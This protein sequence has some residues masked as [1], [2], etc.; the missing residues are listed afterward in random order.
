MCAGLQNTTDGLM[1]WLRGGGADYQLSTD[2]GMATVFEVH[3]ETYTASNGVVITPR[4]DLTN[5]E[6]E[7]NNRWTNRNSTLYSQGYLV[8][9]A[10]NY[11][12]YTV[13]KTGSGASGT[14]GI[15]ISGN[16]NTAT[17]LATAR[18]F[19]IADNDGTNKGPTVSFNGSTNAIINLP[20]V[21]KASLSG[22]AS[23]AT[24]IQNGNYSIGITSNLTPFIVVNGSQGRVWGIERYNTDYQL[25]EH[26]YNNGTYET[27]RISLNNV[28]YSGYALPLSGGTLTGLLTITTN[29]RYV[30]LGCQNQSFAHYSTNADSGHWF[31]TNVR[32]QGDI[33][34]GNSYDKKV[35]SED[36]GYLSNQLISHS[37]NG[38][39]WISGTHSAAF[40]VDTATSAPAGN[41]YQ[42]WY[43]GK[44]P[45][46]AWSLGCLAGDESM[47]FVYGSDADFQAGTNNTAQLRMTSSGVLFGAA[48]NDYAEFRQGQ[49]EYKPGTCV[50]EVG[51]DTLVAS[52]ERLQG[53]AL[54]VSDTFGFAI[55]ETDE[56]K[57]PIATSGRVLAYTFEPRESY[58]AGD[59]VCSGPN[60]TVSKMTE[61]EVMM[62]PHKMIGTVSAIPDYEE[63]GTGKVKVDGR[64][65]IQVR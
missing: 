14:W 48:W 1:V 39:M 11:T 18:T 42:A 36:G 54:I 63:W 56:A 32:V 57:T 37:V 20:S 38:G 53:G 33:Y 17:T 23:S 58:S 40:V 65:W 15:N 60:G 13:S 47:Y 43:S 64:I 62:Y 52:T 50:I 5:V 21:I 7:I 28:N 4:T 34:C 16:A 6:T 3:Y 41:Y 12:S 31:N 24:K 35:I 25:Y 9:S 10:N 8:L 51:D 26:Y 29:N 61:Q 45:A 30:T 46:G 2:Y 59:P 19:Q 27:S 55:G 44:T 49:Q 22:N